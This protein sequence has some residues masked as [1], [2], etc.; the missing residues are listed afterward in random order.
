MTALK[1]SE[2][3]QA[4][5]CFPITLDGHRLPSLWFYPSTVAQGL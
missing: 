2:G 4:E 1:T 3:K 5:A